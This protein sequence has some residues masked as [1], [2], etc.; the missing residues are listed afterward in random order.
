MV[1]AEDSDFA[2]GYLHIR[3]G[4]AKLKKPRTVVLLQPVIDALQTHL[5]GKTEG[6]VF[7]SLTKAGDHL[8]SRAVQKI[9]V[10]IAERS[11]LQQVKYHDSAGAARKRIH[12]H[13]LRH[14][15]T[16]WSLDSGVPIYDLQK[17]L[18][19]ASLAATGIYPEASPKHRKDSYLKS[20][21]SDCLTR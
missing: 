18:E 8:T 2:K 20:R 21:V 15:F 17:Q 11:G 6:W 13:L 5:Q 3:A 19:H 12:P 16:M 1:R 9:L 4:N 7:K 14:P 10:A